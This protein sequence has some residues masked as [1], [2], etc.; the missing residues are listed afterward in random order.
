MRESAKIEKT[1]LPE[2]TYQEWLK[3]Q[4]EKPSPKGRGKMVTGNSFETWV[5]KRVER[6][7]KK[8]SGGARP[9]GH[10]PRRTV[11]ANR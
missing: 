2:D 3:S 11:R 5:T 10:L 4:K 9:K 8:A 6:Q 7:V 1:R